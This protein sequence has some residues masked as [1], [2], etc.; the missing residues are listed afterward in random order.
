MLI[1][2]NKVKKKSNWFATCFIGLFI[3]VSLF[4]YINNNYD[5]F[6]SNGQ[7]SVD[8]RQKVFVSGT[9]KRIDYYNEDD[10]V[11]IAVDKGYATLIVKKIGQFEYQESY[12]DESG[13]PIALNDGYYGKLIITDV[14]N[15]IIEEKYLDQ[16]AQPIITR[17]G[18]F[19][20]KNRYND[21]NQLIEEKYYDLNNLPCSSV[22]GC[23][24]KSF[25][26][27]DDGTI[28]I[29]N[30]LDKNSNLLNIN[31][32][33]A[34]IKYFYSQAGNKITMLYFDSKGNPVQLDNG[35]Y[36]E[37]HYGYTVKYLDINGNLI[38][39]FK[40]FMSN[41]PWLVV[42]GGLLLCCLL[43]LNNRKF[44]LII[45]ALYVVFVIGETLINRSTSDI[46]LNFFW[47]YRQIFISRSLRVEIL[48]N[49][50]L[51]IPLGAGVYVVFGKIIY[52]VL[53]FFLS[54]SIEFLQYV[55]HL[56]LC[57]LDDIFSNILGAFVGFVIAYVINKLTSKVREIWSKENHAFK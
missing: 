42:I 35:Q 34:S 53:L 49:I 56:G 20:K 39:N 15:N 32:G 50:W 12:L 14:N 43:N 9:E 24:G 28:A 26:Y 48:D 23:Y 29:E 57:E 21:N 17:F 54:L 3:F 1:S 16:N 18:I 45:L 27:N 51:F 11:S 46:N 47:S 19:T 13:N 38:F 44:Q 40:Q 30:Y 5:Y 36:G 25:Q 31:E 55:F 2:L 6:V 37:I 22:D 52:I 4:L 8:L 10:K 33:F 41:Y 7:N